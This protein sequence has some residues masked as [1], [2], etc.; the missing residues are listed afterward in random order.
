MR[1][2]PRLILGL[3]FLISPLVV[4]AGTLCYQPTWFGTYTKCIGSCSSWYDVCPQR[5]LCAIVATGT[6]P[7]GT[8]VTSPYPCNSFT[9]GTGACTTCVGGT[10]AF[11]PTLTTIPNQTCG[12]TACP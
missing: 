3:S 11:P 4:F 6:T 8:I 5:V 10:P 12:T 7:S 1:V 9:G 2:Q